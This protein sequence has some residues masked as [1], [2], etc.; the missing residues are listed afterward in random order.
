MKPPEKSPY[1]CPQGHSNPLPLRPGQDC[2]YCVTERAWD[3][4]NGRV[5][6]IDPRPQEGEALTQVRRQ[7]GARKSW[8]WALVIA[9]SFAAG[10][11]I[12]LYLFFSQR[13]GSDI[14]SFLS[15]LY[16]LSAAAALLGALAVVVS[17]ESAYY[18][19]KRNYL[20]QLR[21]RLSAISVLLFSAVTLCAALFSWMRVGVF[22]Q[23]P[24][25]VPGSSHAVHERIN[26]A[27]AIIFSL[28]E[29]N[30][31][32]RP[33]MCT[34]AIV[35]VKDGRTWVLAAPYTRLSGG[36]SMIV[37]PNLQVAFADGSKHSGRI[38]VV[39]APPL[40]FALIEVYTQNPPGQVEIPHAGESPPPGG[41]VWV[42]IPPYL[43]WSL[44][45]GVVLK[46][47]GFRA[48]GERVFVYTDLPP[49]I[50]D[51]G[52]CVYSSDG[53]LVGF[54]VGV[55][56]KGAATVIALTSEVVEKIIESVAKDT[57]DRLDELQ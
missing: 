22:P 10:G 44:Q 16:H 47:E 39:S 3:T 46:R 56:D 7:S 53:R 51:A 55:D 34:G 45:S 17:A 43:G 9:A 31:R 26:A 25:F 11:D 2:S 29:K 32:Y 24:R 52:G 50:I 23:L 37:S 5:L 28:N 36:R 41:N 13:V 19:H 12:L 18:A 38:R 27:T 33:Y 40:N 35:G 57:P 8:V 1:L 42:S 15:R 14:E 20:K 30:N 4:Y 6:V 54:N 48:A 21:L 49:R